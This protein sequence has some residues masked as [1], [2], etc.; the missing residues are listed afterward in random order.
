ML[1]H[2]LGIGLRRHQ[3]PSSWLLISPALE[4]Q[5]NC[6]RREAYLEL[7]HC[8]DD[9][10]MAGRAVAVGE[11]HEGSFGIYMAHKMSKLRQQTDGAV[12]RLAGAVQSTLR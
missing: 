11:H 6:G 2:Y 3:Y 9:A 5:W 12:A 4:E 8:V 7:S 1:G 10:E